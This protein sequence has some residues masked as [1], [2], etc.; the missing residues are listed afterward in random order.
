MGMMHQASAGYNLTCFSK[1]DTPFHHFKYMA[2]A[3]KL[4]DAAARAASSDPDLA[5]RVR[6]SRLPLGYVWL[7][8]WRQLQ[9]ECADMGATSALAPENRHSA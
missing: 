7:T 8:R 5:L 1:T 6:T 2:E 9:K 4:W 3:E